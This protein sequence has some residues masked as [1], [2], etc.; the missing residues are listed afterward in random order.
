MKLIVTTELKQ[1]SSDQDLADL[2]STVKQLDLESS[3][4]QMG[5]VDNMPQ[6]M[7]ASDILVPLSLIPLALPI[8][9]W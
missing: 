4:I 1:S 7:Q 8:I 9:S 2:E 6:L 3:L 5:I